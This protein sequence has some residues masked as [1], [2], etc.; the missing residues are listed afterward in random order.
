[1]NFTPN[2][3][4]RCNQPNLSPNLAVEDTEKHLVRCVS[5]P[6]FVGIGTEML[7]LQ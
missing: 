7:D 4:I 2:T 5:F 6:S 1:M 3:S